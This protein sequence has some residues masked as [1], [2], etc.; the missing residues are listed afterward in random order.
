MSRLPVK[1]HSTQVLAETVRRF[2]NAYTVLEDGQLVTAK[3]L[4]LIEEVPVGGKQ[5]HDANLVA[6]MLVH[7]VDRIV[8]ANVSDL[9]RFAGFVEILPL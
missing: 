8:T 6:T 2:A 5:I 7:G 9:K 1:E 4:E 3:L